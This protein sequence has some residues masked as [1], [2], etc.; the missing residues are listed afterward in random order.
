MR[1]FRYV[2]IVLI[3]VLTSFIYDL[4]A[5]S[6]TRVRLYLTFIQ[7]LLFIFELIILA[8]HKST[9]EKADDKPHK[10]TFQNTYENTNQNSF[11]KTFQASNSWAYLR[12]NYGADYRTFTTA[13]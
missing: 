2:V 4:E 7:I 5:A 11:C 10:N 9:N 1:F 12:S 8:A 3:F 13:I 6:P